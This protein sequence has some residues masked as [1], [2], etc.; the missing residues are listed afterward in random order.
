MIWDWIEFFTYRHFGLVNVNRK[1]RRIQKRFKMGVESE[2]KLAIIEADALLDEILKEMGYAGQTLGERLDTLTLDVLANLE[3]VRKAHQIRSDIVHDLSYHLDRETAK[4]VLNIYEKNI[5]IAGKH[6]GFVF[7]TLGL[8]PIDVKDMSD[9]E[10]D[11]YLD[12]ILKP[13]ADI[14]NHNISILFNSVLAFKSLHYYRPRAHK[15]T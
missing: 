13:E 2:S 12:F 7:L 1:W 5:E 11:K 15:I 14:S 10:V 4:K 3:E 6:K 8:H 9:E